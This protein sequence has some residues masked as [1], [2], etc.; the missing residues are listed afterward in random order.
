MNKMFDPIGTVPELSP[1]LEWML[2]SDQVS[3]SSLLATLIYEYY[4]EVYRLSLAILKNPLKAARA[5]EETFINVVL[6]HHRYSP[7]TSIK[8]WLY[9]ITVEACWYI[10]RK[11]EKGF[12]H[13]E[14]HRNDLVTIQRSSDKNSSEDSLIFINKLNEKHRIPLLLDYLFD[15]DNSE[16]SQVLKIHE[17]LVVLR[18]QNARQILQE[19]LVDERK[20]DNDSWES[21]IRTKIKERYPIPEVDEALF[22]TINNNIYPKIVKRRDNRRFISTVREISIGGIAIVLVLLFGW[23]LGLLNPKPRNEEASKLIELATQTPHHLYKGAF[24][25]PTPN[26]S[27]HLISPTPV[28]PVP[29]SAP[30]KETDHI[31]YILARIRA[32][33]DS[34]RTLW[35]DATIVDYG[36]LGYAGPPQVYRN[37]V[38]IS[39]PD[40]MLI[41]GGPPTAVADY[42]R[43]VMGNNFYEMDLKNGMAYYP[44][45]IDF[46]P[47]DTTS[48]LLIEHVQNYSARNQ[49]YGFYLSNILSPLSSDISNGNYEVIGEST[50]SGRDS[51]VLAHNIEGVTKDLTWIDVKTGVILGWRLFD[52]KDPRI[53]WRDIF[54]T[55][56]SFDFNFPR[57]FFYQQP[58][59]GKISWLDIWKP[60]S[61]Y[62]AINLQSNRSLTSGHEIRPTPFIKLPDGW[63]PSQGRLTF[64]WSI[65]PAQTGE[66]DLFSDDFYLGQVFKMGDPWSLLCTRSPDGQKIAFIESPDIPI[67][68][69]QGIYWFSLKNP[70]EVHTLL[71]NGTV[72]SDVAFSPD[73]RYLAYFGCGGQDENCGVYI[74]DTQTLK[75]RKFIAAAVAGYFTW[76]PDGQYLAMVA[77]AGKSNMSL[78]VYRVATAEMVYYGSMNWQT[79][80]PAPDSP[81]NQWGVEFPPE[82][83]GLE[84]CVF[85]PGKQVNPG[86]GVPYHYYQK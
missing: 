72:A 83:G 1:D 73:S 63:D 64:Q 27:D 5:V 84:G 42:L 52:N 60:M 75:N 35:A 2:Q 10:Q 26:P 37:Q 36:P 50:S 53:V 4:A 28:K 25:Y 40:Q 29:E 13:T 39:Q 34:W 57:G 46:L 62:S 81:T 19:Q 18:L 68:A 21:K 48:K 58:S 77:A 86:L 23:I 49:L 14:D 78:H 51:L 76:S 59:G 38:W 70:Q 3:D 54:I 30:I 45:S 55:A 71:S 7:D 15:L 12:S 67:Y 44:S 11:D 47:T 66:T 61:Q 56:I 33:R 82:M 85:P 24:I 41:L 74:Y 16:I 79:M 8:I 20:S 22:N 65:E 43:V 80:L 6:K 17:V 32:S 31:T 9:S 69:S